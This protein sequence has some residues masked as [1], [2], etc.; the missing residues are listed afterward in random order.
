MEYVDW[1]S[2]VL[3]FLLVIALLGA[4]LWGLKR[5]GRLQLQ[6][7]SGQASIKLIDSFSLGARQRIVLVESD[8]QRILVGISPQSITGLGQWPRDRA[9]EFSDVLR[10]AGTQAE[11]SSD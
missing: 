4:T 8:D 2:F 7:Q 3:S 5:F 9:P 10:D 1:V 11:S 6:N